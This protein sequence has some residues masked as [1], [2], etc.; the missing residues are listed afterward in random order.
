MQSAI[1]KLETE[2]A[3]VDH[4]LS[5]GVFGRT[6]NNLARLL[7]FVCEK[8]FEGAIDQIKEYSIAVY[9]LGRPESFD[10]QVDTVV[11]VTAHALRKRLDDY[12][13]T[14]GAGRAVY[15]CL[16]PGRYIPKFI[17]R[18]DLEAPSAE[19]KANGDPSNSLLDGHLSN[20]DDQ[21]QNQSS[22]LARPL[23]WPEPDQIE[24]SPNAATA[25]SGRWMRLTAVVVFAIAIFLV[26][27]YAWKKWN[28]KNGQEGRAEVSKQAA[29]GYT[30]AST[31]RAMIG[32]SSIPYVGRDGFGWGA[33]HFCSGGIPFSVTGQAIQGTEEP[34]LFSSGR[35]GIFHCKFP[36]SKGT[37]ELHLLF[38]ETDGL[39]ENSRHMGFSIDD[40]PVSHLD[41]VDDAGGDDIA[42]TKVFTDV[43]PENDGT[44]HVDFITADAFVNAIEIVPGTPHRMLPL[45][46]VVAHSPYRDSNGNLW[47]SDRYFLGG[48]V[49]T[50]AGDLPKLPSGIFQ[51]HRFGHFRYVLPVVPGGKYTVNL[52]FLEHW[53]GNPNGGLGGA[54]SRVFDVYCDGSTLLKGFDI[55]REGGSGPVIKNFQ[56]IEPTP[57]GKIE[58]NFVPQVNYASVSAIEVLPE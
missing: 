21:A 27:R 25:T 23:H 31:V 3:E 45:R 49:S 39:Q 48:R 22:N 4:L 11:R 54:G 1:S 43:T 42:T 38:A 8:H 18:S 58:L 2:R 44:I 15:I 14:A 55:F 29:V 7:T 33:D 34:L 57:Q 30:P 32:Y 17:H 9:A 47:M 40:G 56:H 16:P 28:A 6:N 46:I 10:P 37:Y 20:G 12:Y 24:N 36:V 26:A 35:R 13:K 51:G 41:V 50:F 19:S 5:S 52:Y 53:F